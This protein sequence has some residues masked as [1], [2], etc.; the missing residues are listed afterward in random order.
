MLVAQRDALARV[1]D[2]P[3]LSPRQRAFLATRLLH[4]NDTEAA[5]A[6]GVD[7]ATVWRWQKTE[8]FATEHRALI[9]AGPRGVVEF[10]RSELQRL[11]G[12][13]PQTLSDLLT[14]EEEVPLG[15]T[16]AT[17]KRPAWLARAKALEL[18]YRPLGMWQ[19]EA[20]APPPSDAAAA[21]TALA[22]MIALRRA[23]IEAG[24]TPQ[25]AQQKPVPDAPIIEG[26]SLET[27]GSDS[28]NAR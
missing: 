22:E 12:L 28:G 7:R 17:F 1:Q 8:P 18:L 15:K 19:P 21:F 20:A 3:G 24:A 16:G 9:E 11:A 25:A 26:T 14:A 6:A 27:G 5:T 23:E 4:E 13:A 10:V 2:A